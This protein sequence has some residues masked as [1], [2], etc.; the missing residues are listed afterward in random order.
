MKRTKKS[1]KP[2]PSQPNPH[3]LIG[4]FFHSLKDGRIFWQGHIIGYPQPGW[5]LVELFEYGFGEVCNR[6]LVSFESMKDWLFYP[7][8]ELMKYSYE[9]GIAR[10]GGP[11]RPHPPSPPDRPLPE[12]RPWIDIGKDEELPQRKAK[13]DSQ[14]PKPKHRDSSIPYSG[15]TT[16]PAAKGTTRD[17]TT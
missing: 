1:S 5:Y 2:D 3:C 17:T 4:Q 8:S 16:N 11:Y 7:D 15:E 6:H 14:G 13:P 12:A 9:Y 10:M